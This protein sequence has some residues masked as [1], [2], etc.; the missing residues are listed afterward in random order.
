M[1][2]VDVIQIH[3]G[4]YFLDDWTSIVVYFLSNAQTWRGDVAR[5]VK[6]ELKWRWEKKRMMR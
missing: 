6:K 5:E 1:T 4:K 3:D 2:T